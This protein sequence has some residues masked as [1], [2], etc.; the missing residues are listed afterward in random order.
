[1]RLVAAATLVAAC[2]TP[3]GLTIEV[4]PDDGAVTTVELIVGTHCETCGSTMGAPAIAPRSAMIYAAEHPE[5]WEAPVDG[6][7]AGFVLHTDGSD[8][9]RIPVLLAVGFDANGRAI[10]WDKLIDVI[11]PPTGSAYWQIHLAPIEPI[12]DH[13][14]APDGSERVAVWRATAQTEPSC[15]MIE[16]WYEGSP[17][18]S[19]VVP[20]ADPDCD[21]IDPQLDCAPTVPDAMSVPPTFDSSSCLVNTSVGGGTTCVLG[22]PSCTDGVPASMTACTRL[23]TDYCVAGA[24]CACAPADFGCLFDKLVSGT[25]D[26]T[27]TTIRCQVPVGSDG[28]LCAGATTVQL[29]ASGLLSNGRVCTDLRVVTGFLAGGT[30]YVDSLT[31]GMTG[32]LAFGNFQPNCRLDV[33]WSG[34][35]TPPVGTNIDVQFADLILDN[36]KHIVVPLRTDTV[37]NCNETFQCTLVKSTTTDTAQ[38]CAK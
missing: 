24:L 26:G 8:E 25:A 15:V 17:H 9:Q 31:I 7:V 23:P 37:L 33:T 14:S 4:L 19:A 36:G 30:Q 16:K 28:T 11:I 6:G 38:L 21:H 10:A 12:V 27:V 3:P 2:A 35:L 22:G 5:V 34:A 18:T 13:T 32:T 1:M 20:P 29:D